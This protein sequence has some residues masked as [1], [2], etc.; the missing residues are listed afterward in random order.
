M[1]HRRRP[2][3]GRASNPQYAWTTMGDGGFNVAVPGKVIG[4]T[5]VTSDAPNT[6]VRTR[7]TVGCVLN[8]GAAAEHVLVRF[9]LIKVSTDAFAAGAASVP[10]PGSDRDQ[11]WVWTGQLFLSSGEEAAVINEGLIRTL[12]VD[13]KAMR[14]FKVNEVYVFVAE[15]L[16]GEIQ[17][18]AGTIDF[19]Y[20]ID[21]LARF[22]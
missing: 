2:G 8:A 16:A 13:S 1:A 4:A 5:G 15:T 18:Q 6:L 12:H 19:I 17:D 22:N 7:G 20:A 10:G 11:D 21:C 3:V 14:K 9:G